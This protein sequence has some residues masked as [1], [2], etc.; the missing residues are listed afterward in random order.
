MEIFTIRGH[1]LRNHCVDRILARFGAVSRCL[2]PRQVPVL[3]GFCRAEGRTRRRHVKAT[4]NA[5]KHISAAFWWDSGTF[6]CI[7]VVLWEIL[8]DS[9]RLWET[10][11]DSGTGLSLAAL[12]LC[13]QRLQEAR[14][15][16]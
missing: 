11:E 1:L 4:R 16:Q 7:L 6:W 10:L 14:P 15:C 5:G 12:S 2:F 9:G 8:V 3:A 13:A